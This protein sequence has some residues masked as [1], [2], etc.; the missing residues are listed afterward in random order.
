MSAHDVAVVIVTYNSEDE[1]AACLD[2]VQSE[3][4][5]VSMEVIVVD[6][7]SSDS[8]VEVIRERYPWVKL[9]LPGENLGFSKGVNYGARHA[10]ADFVLLLNP[11]TVVRRH[12]IDV[13]VDFAR[14][15][16][17]YGLYG[18]RLLLLFLKSTLYKNRSQRNPLRVMRVIKSTHKPAQEQSGA[19]IR[20]L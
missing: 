17:Q 11:D 1:I 14:E 8:T 15:N 13:I 3:R 12:A 16:P 9:L 2:A 20:F 18:G 10:D 6:N 7:A 5:E 19:E 4:R